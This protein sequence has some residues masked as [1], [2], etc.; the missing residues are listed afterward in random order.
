MDRDM[1]LAR[2][3][4]TATAGWM[5]L[6]ADITERPG[7]RDADASLLWRWLARL[8]GLRGVLAPSDAQYRLIWPQGGVTTTGTLALIAHQDPVA[9]RP[10]AHRS[11]I[12]AAVLDA[13]QSSNWQALATA[14]CK[15]TQE[16]VEVLRVTLDVDAA[17]P[18][19]FLLVRSGFSPL[20]SD[21]LHALDMLFAYLE[22]SSRSGG[23][24]RVDLIF[25]GLRRTAQT[26]PVVDAAN[27]PSRPTRAVQHLVEVL[28]LTEAEARVVWAVYRL[29]RLEK[30]AE[31]L[32][33]SPHTL[34]THLKHVFE[35]VGVH[36]RA[37]LMVRVATLVQGTPLLARQPASTV[38]TV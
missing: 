27:V 28:R 5:R 9:F 4:A 6:L 19:E 35:K 20:A 18:L 14:L 8:I 7:R 16:H 24:R 30:A 33:I 1:L 23:S 32:N 34:R 29:E 21:A 31:S 3:D 26:E 25:E 38:S 22:Q 15:G 17:Q 12:A 10:L 37:A 36:S 13:A 2:A 11:R